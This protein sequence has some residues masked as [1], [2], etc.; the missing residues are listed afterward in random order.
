M[1]LIQNFNKNKNSKN[2]NNRNKKRAKSRK[3]LSLPKKIYLEEGYDI[4]YNNNYTENNKPFVPY[5]TYSYENKK[6]RINNLINLNR[7]METNEEKNIES[8]TVTE[9]KLLFI[10]VNILMKNNDLNKK[11]K[12]KLNSLEINKNED[13]C[14]GKNNLIIKCNNNNRHIS[15][16][17]LIESNNSRNNNLSELQKQNF[18]T[19]DIISNKKDKYL[20]SC[21]KFM[22]KIINKIFLNKEYIYFK[23]YILNIKQQ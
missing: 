8:I 20:L 13:F 14:I 17:S 9:D 19:T 6:Y 18:P 11:E 16:F 10:R 3:K 22:I 21:I 12:Y 5:R 15:S 4:N 23:K 2:K 7:V 1:S